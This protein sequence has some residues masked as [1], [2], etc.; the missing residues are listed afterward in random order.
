MVRKSY[1]E[2]PPL[3]SGRTLEDTAFGSIIEVRGAFALAECMVGA[4]SLAQEMEARRSRF[5]ST[6]AR[7][8]TRVMSLNYCLRVP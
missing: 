4:S 2:G 7:S 3:C 6:M 5:A 1:S 8:P